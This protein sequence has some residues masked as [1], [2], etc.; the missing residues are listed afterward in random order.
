MQ[1]QSPL[2]V[3]TYDIR[4]GMYAVL[5]S[6]H[7]KVST[8]EENLSVLWKELAKDKTTKLVRTVHQSHEIVH[9]FCNR[10]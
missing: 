5:V 9:L 7:L 10:R 8:E 2:M 3:I 1:N 6:L 4:S